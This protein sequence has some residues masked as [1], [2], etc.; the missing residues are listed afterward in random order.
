MK[1]IF[2]SVCLLVG[3]TLFGQVEM[4]DL[5]PRTVVQQKV[6]LT[7]FEL[8]Y[9]RP[10]VRERTIFGDVLPFGEMW[11]TGAN[12]N[13][14]IS[15]DQDIVVAGSPIEKGT[16]AL[17][18]KI[19]ENDWDIYFYT[20][21]ENWG[22]PKELDE[23]KIALKLTLSSV[24][25]A[26]HTETFTISFDNLGTDKFDLDVKWENR[27]VTMPIELFT[28]DQA[29]ASIEKVMAGPTDR[30]FYAAASF[31]LDQ[32]TNLE[33]ALAYIKKA[34]A[35]RGEQ[36]FWYTRKQAL[37]EYALGDVEAAIAS[38]QLSLKYAKEANYTSYI[39]MNEASIAE[40][41]KKK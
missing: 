39:K 37:I 36:T 24:N 38:A 26:P 35:L 29:L 34:V 30:D 23:E 9:S 27:S 17:F 31:Y 18:T 25:D 21:T 15:F 20:D 5:S 16:Y 40:W 2:L 14:M 33:E 1:N 19:N 28:N 22:V 6:G 11:R 41:S 7:N 10:S 3:S 8:E 4:P 12:K 13:S 32:G